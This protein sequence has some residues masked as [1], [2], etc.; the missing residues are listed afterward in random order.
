MKITNQISQAI[1]PAPAQIM[2]RRDLDI[3]FDVLDSAVHSAL[4]PRNNMLGWIDF[5]RKSA[6]RGSAEYELYEE[7]QK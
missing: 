1:L 5:Q 6:T 2:E 3:A 4:L 7:P